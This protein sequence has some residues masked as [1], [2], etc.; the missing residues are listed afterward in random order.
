M[1]FENYIEFLISEERKKE[2]PQIDSL[3]NMKRKHQEEVRIL[4]KAIANQSQEKIEF[5]D[6]PKYYEKL[7]Q[8]KH[9]GPMIKQMLNT[10]KLIEQKNAPRIKKIPIFTGSNLVKKMVDFWK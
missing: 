8:L 4:E 5:E 10:A 6:V 3:Q 7:L 2:K 9:S 1:F